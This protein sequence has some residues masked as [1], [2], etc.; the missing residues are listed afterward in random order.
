MA[1]GNYGSGFLH[2]SAGCGRK[3]GLPEV[4]LFASEDAREGIQAYTEKR[5]AEFK[6]R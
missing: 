2:Q 3:V 4:G 6:G 5:K 1:P